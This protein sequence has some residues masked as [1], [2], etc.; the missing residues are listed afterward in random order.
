MKK[1]ILLMGIVGM[2]SYPSSAQIG[3]NTETPEQE[4]H[5]HPLNKIATD[6]TKDIVF[7]SDGIVGIGTTTPDATTKLDVVGDISVSGT[8]KVGNTVDKKGALIVSGNGNVTKTIGVGTKTPTDFVGLHI[9]NT[10]NTTNDH[11]LR[12]KDG[13]ENAGYMLTAD[14]EGN[15]YW[16][17]LR[18]MA[19]VV[20]GQLADGVAVE[21][22]P[23][24]ITKDSLELIPGRWL[25]F[26]KSSVAGNNLQGFT[27]YMRLYAEAGFKGLAS[28]ANGGVYL[29]AS[30]SPSETGSASA[31]ANL[32]IP[33]YASSPNLSYVVDVPIK[34]GTKPGTPE[35]YTKFWISLS[36]S[37]NSTTTSLYGDMQFYALRLDRP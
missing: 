20:Y 6:K 30:A 9:D 28:D 37:R 18:P 5:I 2:Y 7:T 13:T 21:L 11:I 8:T 25:I 4:L 17:A 35:Y 33:G 22:T 31:N 26:A 29:S 27:M 16:S 23:R 36:C 12:L 10:N 19:S 34:A 24:S 1:F 32:G 15:A 14:N 3:I